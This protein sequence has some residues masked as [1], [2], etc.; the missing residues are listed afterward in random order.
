MS[1]AMVVSTIGKV[2]PPSAESWRACGL[3]R[4]MDDPEIAGMAQRTTSVF[5]DAVEW[6][7]GALH[8]ELDEIRFDA[9]IED[10]VFTKRNL[11][12]KR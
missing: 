6:M 9:E 11:T 4:P 2:V 8:L 10:S 3:G 5:E 1:G 7:A 12:K